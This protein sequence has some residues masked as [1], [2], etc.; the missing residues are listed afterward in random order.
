MLNTLALWY[1]LQRVLA[2]HNNKGCEKRIRCALFC[3]NILQTKLM[4][5]DLGGRA[6]EREREFAIVFEILRRSW[7]PLKGPN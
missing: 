2:V 5:L 7:C 4:A 3:V 6:R 1:I